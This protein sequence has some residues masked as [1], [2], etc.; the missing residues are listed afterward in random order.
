MSAEMLREGQCWVLSRFY[1]AGT[2]WKRIARAFGYLAPSVV[3][4]AMAPLNLGY[5]MRHHAFRTAEK[6]RGFAA[7]GGREAFGASPAAAGRTPA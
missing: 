3:L 6:A 2:T 1:S 7:G 4:R 5:R